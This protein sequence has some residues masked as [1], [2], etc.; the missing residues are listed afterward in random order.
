MDI[1]N[2][3]KY[4]VSHSHLYWVSGQIKESL[5]DVRHADVP[6]EKPWNGQIPLDKK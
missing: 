3:T 5:L 6:D 4:H 1:Y 2:N